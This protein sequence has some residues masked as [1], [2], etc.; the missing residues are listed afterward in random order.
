M[1][2]KHPKIAGKDKKKRR[3]SS[4]ECKR[5][6]EINYPHHVLPSLMKRSPQRAGNHRHLKSIM[7]D[8]DGEV[9][10]ITPTLIA[11]FGHYSSNL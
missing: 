8:R 4:D 6:N 7:R 10:T 2:K 3:K 5:Q 11:A 9:A 1:T